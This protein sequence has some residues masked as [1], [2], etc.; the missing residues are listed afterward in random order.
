[1]PKAA[2]TSPWYAPW[3]NSAAEH[4][5]AADLGTAFGL[6]MSMPDPDDID[7]QA[8]ARKDSEPGWV[9]RWTTRRHP[10]T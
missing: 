8:P 3:R 9:Q 7:A 1:M 2:P 6:D 10:S 4:D 5:D